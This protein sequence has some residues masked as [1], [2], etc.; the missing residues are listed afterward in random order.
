MVIAAIEVAR[1]DQ[2]MLQ[3]HRVV[4]AAFPGA[5]LLDATG[6]AEVFSVATRV[7]DAGRPGYV[8]RIATPDG[9]P[10]TTSSG[11]RVMAD[12]TLTEVDDDVDTLLI[13]GAVTVDASGVSPVL[14]RGI[15]EPRVRQPLA[16]RPQGRIRPTN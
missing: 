12:L 7:A 16:G 2:P 4:M 8:V 6:P 13:S 9:E 14:H 10:V 1:N 15:V 5:E 3:P 11:V